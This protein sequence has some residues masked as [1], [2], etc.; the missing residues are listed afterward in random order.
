MQLQINP[1]FQNLIRPLTP[2]EFNLLE[3]SLKKDG[4]R[5]PITILEDQSYVA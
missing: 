5:E 2:E 3:I 4:C 1:D